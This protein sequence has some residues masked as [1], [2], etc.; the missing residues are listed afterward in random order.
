[1]GLE[2]LHLRKPE[3]TKLEYEELLKA[4]PSEHKRKVML[5]QH[6]D[7]AAKYNVKGLHLKEESRHKLSL[8][9]VKELK[10]D[11]SRKNMLFSSSFHEMNE[12]GTYDGLFDYVFLSPVFES[13]SKSEYRANPLLKEVVKMKGTKVIALGGIQAENIVLTK[14]YG[15]DGVAVL[16]AIWQDPTHSLPRF[17]EIQ[18]QHAQQFC[19]SKIL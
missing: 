18:F 11:L 14:A 12:M 2:T 10:R 6:H 16:G 15:F 19:N 7:L 5:H 1:M 17:K 13:I 3:M 4:I 9:E 8:Q